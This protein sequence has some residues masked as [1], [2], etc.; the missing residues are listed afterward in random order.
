M[1]PERMVSSNRTDYYRERENREVKRTAAILDTVFPNWYRFVDIEKLD[2]ENPSR[3]VLAQAFCVN[4]LPPH[5]AELR[6]YLMI[7]TPYSFGLL[8]VDPDHRFWGIFSSNDF[9]PAWKQE[10]TRRVQNEA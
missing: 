4:D 3:C 8:V 10:I 2:M 7:P 9:L 6:D 1:F 5:L